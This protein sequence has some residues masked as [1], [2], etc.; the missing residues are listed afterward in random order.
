MRKYTNEEK[1]LLAAKTPQYLPDKCWSLLLAGKLSEWDKRFTALGKLRDAVNSNP[2][3]FN[4]QVPGTYRELSQKFAELTA[5][6]R[7]AME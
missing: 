1:E 6:I 3:L 5:L 2:A 7:Q 4:G